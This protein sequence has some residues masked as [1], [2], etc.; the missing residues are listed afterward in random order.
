ME[1]IPLLNIIMEGGK[2]AIQA[3]S[4]LLH[5]LRVPIFLISLITSIPVP[6]IKGYISAYK[7]N[8]KIPEPKLPK[9]KKKL[10]EDDR[11]K[12]LEVYMTHPSKFD[13]PLARWTLRRLA[14]ILERFSI[15]V[16]HET[17]RQ[18][19]LSAGIR[20]RRSK[21]Y[22]KSP[23][24]LYYQKKKML[25]EL[26]ENI[27]KDTGLIYVDESKKAAKE[28]PGEGWVWDKLRHKSR[29]KTGGVVSFFLS[30]DR[31]DRRFGIARRGYWNWEKF[32]EFVCLLAW[33]YKKMGY[34]RIILVI[35][36]SSYHKKAVKG[37]ANIGSAL[38]IEVM[39]FYL[40]KGSPWLNP[41]EAEWSLF[42]RLYLPFKD[43]RSCGEL[44]YEFFRFL[45]DR[46]EQ[47][48][49]AR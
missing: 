27:P 24:P 16:S 17:V 45:G 37:I 22:I 6:T 8:L 2:K 43:L 19:L 23:D 11:K 7:R 26:E 39:W 49:K 15:F 21:P 28:Y 5:K 42:K 20:F 48:M 3:K 12:I 46:N 29:Q 25:E 38:G 35:D 41:V 13:L 10:S 4:I 14:Q 18:V 47:R 32:L 1:V 31:E 34:R 33:E 44:I 30:K 40:P 36:N 9:L